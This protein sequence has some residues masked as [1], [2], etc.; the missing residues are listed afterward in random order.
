MVIAYTLIEKRYNSKNCTPSHPGMP[1]PTLAV[2]PFIAKVPKTNSNIIQPLDPEK[3]LRL[4]NS[5][6]CGTYIEKEVVTFNIDNCG[7]HSVKDG[8]AALS[9]KYLVGFFLLHPEF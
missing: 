3:F 9:R 5:L 6:V 4:S 7:S 2:D 1:S 8:K